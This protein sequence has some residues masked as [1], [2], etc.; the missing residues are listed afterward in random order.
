M[1]KC[2]LIQIGLICANTGYAQLFSSAEVYIGS[3]AVVA[4]NSELINQ[5]EL[6]S[7]GT[8][9]LRKGMNNQHLMAL[10][11][12]VILDGEG[13]Q[14]IESANSVSVGS[15]LVAQSGKVNLQASFLVQN[16]LCF[17][18]GIIENTKLYS[19]ALA[20]N[21]QVTG[22]SDRSHVKG[23]V[24]KSG[25][26]A[27]D[28]PVG[29]GN[30]LHTFAISKP[31]SSDKISVGFVA[32]NPTRLSTKQAD[33]VAEVTGDSYWA[34]QGEKNQSIQVSITSEQANNRVLQLF[35]NQW[36]IAAGTVVNNRFMAQ[37]ILNNA[38]FFT[39]G[40]QRSEA[41]ENADV[42]VYPNPSNGSFD[43]RLNGFSANE[44]IILDI[45]DL[46]GR[47]LMKQA[48]KVKEMMTKYSLGD[49]ASNGSYFLRVL[50]TEKNQSFVQ[51]LLITK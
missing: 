46:T 34:V 33:A 13:T 24:Q 43:I 22:A 8:L 7:E 3:E 4:V 38:T 50:R 37:T 23:F 16:Q 26:D 5:G 35:D 49:K 12:Q 44:T 9:H 28:F 17:G 30:S 42:S 51:N 41:T 1:K 18:K 45:I 20:D 29:D 2:F 36:N 14:L 32:Q 27:F 21:A 25:D 39:F 11:G 40:I 10:N 19:L 31:A 15:L 47:S 6:K 48:G